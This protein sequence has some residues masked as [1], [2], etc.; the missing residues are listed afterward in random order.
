MTLEGCFVALLSEDTAPEIE[1]MQFE[2]LREMPSWRKI[3]LVGEMWRTVRTLALAGR[4][5]RHSHDSPEQIQRRLAD[6]ML[7][8]HLAEQ[9]S[10]SLSRCGLYAA[11]GRRVGSER[12]VGACTL[13]SKQ[14]QGGGMWWALRS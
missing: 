4:R 1:R 6:L 11:D 3:E 12:P 2:L 8:P 5:E 14:V 7:G 13:A 10:T 9:K